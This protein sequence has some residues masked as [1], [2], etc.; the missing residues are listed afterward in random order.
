MTALIQLLAA[1]VLTID[2]VAVIAMYPHKR[3]QTGFVNS[4]RLSALV[5]GSGCYRCWMIRVQAS[6]LT[7]A[8]ALFWS[9]TYPLPLLLFLYHLV[10]K[11]PRQHNNNSFMG[12]KERRLPM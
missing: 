9:T 1:L 4:C 12:S 6:S 5:G 10:G 11:L 3:K 8:L 2:V 7:L